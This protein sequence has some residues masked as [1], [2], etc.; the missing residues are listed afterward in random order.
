MGSE[1]RN[2]DEGYIHS[3]L[4]EIPRARTWTSG[5]R[6]IAFHNVPK[7]G[8]TM[9]RNTGSCTPSPI[10]QE[11]KLSINFCTIYHLIISSITT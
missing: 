9:A 7:K 1:R 11:R 10:F 6:K 3:P 8:C 5:A 4:G 2:I